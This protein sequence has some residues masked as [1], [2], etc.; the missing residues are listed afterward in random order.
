MQIVNRF[1]GKE[2]GLLLMPPPPAHGGGECGA[3]G[4]L[5]LPLERFVTFSRLACCFEAFSRPPRKPSTLRLTRQR[6]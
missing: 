2:L 6:A 4:A 5:K 1:G 3:L